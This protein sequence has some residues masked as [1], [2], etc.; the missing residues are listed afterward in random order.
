MRRQPVVA[1]LNGS[2]P[3]KVCSGP[4]HDAPTNLPLDETHWNFAR[5]GRRTGLPLSR[6][7]L[8]GNWEKLIKKG[9]PHG[10]VPVASVSG[11]ARELLERC[12][13]Y[14]KVRESYG[15]NDT[16]LGPIV[17]AVHP[18]VQAR[19]AQR[20]LLALGEQRKRDRQHGTSKRF[21]RA[22]RLRG[23]QEQRMESRAAR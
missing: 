17:R 12:G 15:L 6:C 1:L 7:K 21:N 3:T 20:L 5:S 16:T 10:L 13:S 11:Y 19:T 9:G 8:C 18:T 14:E 22:Q 4:A 23:L 2:F